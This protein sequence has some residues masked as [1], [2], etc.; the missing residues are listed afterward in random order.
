VL[1]ASHQKLEKGSLPPP[2]PKESFFH[3]FCTLFTGFLLQRIDSLLFG[4]LFALIQAG[5]N[6]AKRSEEKS[7]T[8]KEKPFL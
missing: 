3:S 5:N 6:E 4:I 8:W 2:P 7:L 1:L